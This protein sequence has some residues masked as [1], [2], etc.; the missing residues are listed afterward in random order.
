MHNYSFSH[1]IQLK[2]TV[3]VRISLNIDRKIERL[4]WYTQGWYKVNT[5]K[6]ESGL[7]AAKKF[8]NTRTIISTSSKCITQKIPV[9]SFTFTCTVLTDFLEYLSNRLCRGVG[10]TSP[11]NKVLECCQRSLKWLKG[12]ENRDLTNPGSQYNSSNYLTRSWI[13]GWVQLL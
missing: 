9:N 12:P 6:N 13:Q 7:D 2:H 8:C 11:A 10:I 5:A 3:G 4:T 1:D